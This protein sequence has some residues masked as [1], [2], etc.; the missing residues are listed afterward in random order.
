MSSIL[1]LGD[2]S[3][4]TAASYLAGVIHN[5]GWAF[6]Y[7]P[8]GQTADAEAIE[9]PRS[10]FILSDYPAEHL[11][12]PLQQS[13]LQQVSQGAGLLMLGGWESFQGSGGRWRNSSVA[14]ALPVEIAETDDRLNCDQPMLAE[15]TA[16]TAAGHPILKGL[17]WNDRPPCLGGLNQF[18]PQPD[19]HLLLQAQR[20]AAR[21]QEGAFSFAPTET[22]PLLVVGE[23][24]RGR[25]A[26]LATDAAPHWIGGWV[27]WG[28]QR[29]SAQAPGAEEVE[30]G[31]DYAR[32]FTQLLGW[33]GRI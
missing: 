31:E 26:A 8:S 22:Y 17:P 16:E 10:L 24:G 25:T 5:A 20:F 7:V 11:S 1:Y 30:V 9:T 19:A 2:T 29:V 3:L 32:F 4:T 21:R 18:A 33:T 12:E 27:D 14:L 15:T 28:K 13:L 23:Y 6:D